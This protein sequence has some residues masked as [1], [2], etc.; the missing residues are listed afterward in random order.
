[1]KEKEVLNNVYQLFFFPKAYPSGTSVRPDHVVGFFFLTVLND[2]KGT[3][4]H[5]IPRKNLISKPLGHEFTSQK[6]PRQTEKI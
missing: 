3:I 6:K 1:M 2:S 5:E 4:N